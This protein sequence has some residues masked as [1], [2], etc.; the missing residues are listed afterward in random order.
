MVWEKGHQPRA[1]L[2]VQA[3]LIYTVRMIPTR[4][5]ALLTG[6]ICAAALLAAAA[7]ASAQ[8][9]IDPF[10]TPIEATA[11][12]VS[13]NFAEFAVIPDAGGEA[14]RMMHLVDEPGTQAHVRQHDARR[15][16]QRQLRRQDGDAVSRHQRAGVERSACSSQGSER[17]FQ[18]FAFHPQFA[19]RGARGYGKFYTYTDTT[20]I[21]A[22]A[23]L[24]AGAAT[25]RTH[26]TVLLEWT[27]KNPAAAAYDGGAPRELFRAA[28]PFANHNGGEIAFN[29][30]ATPGTPEFGLLYVGF[31]DGGSGGDPYE[32][33]AEPGVGV[34]QDPAHRSARHEQRE[35]QVRHPGVESVRQRQQARHARRD[36]RL[37]R[38]QPAALLVGREDRQDV[39]S[40]TSART[41]SRRSAR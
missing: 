12:V 23:G 13:V 2:W 17:G 38:A 4:A 33:R 11:G 15:A 41:S 24:H 35:R 7:P 27:A 6:S 37:R 25:T 22:D 16:L 39:S 40:P 34:R 20:N 19:Q 36:L 26:D 10:P 31:A 32:P 3:G 28:Q 29:P 14:P 8:L 21:D 5:T 18:S 1:R 30:L 9:S